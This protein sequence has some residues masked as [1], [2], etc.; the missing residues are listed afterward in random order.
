MSGLRQDLYKKAFF[1][2]NTTFCEEHNP[3]IKAKSA[4]QPPADKRVNNFICDLTNRLETMLAEDKN[5]SP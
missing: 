1:V 5:K 4:W 2:N 3:N